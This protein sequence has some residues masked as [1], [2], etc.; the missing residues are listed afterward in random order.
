M[1]GVV[2]GVSDFASGEEWCGQDVHQFGFERRSF[3]VACF[4]VYGVQD[5]DAQDVDP[6]ATGRSIFDR[7]FTIG[8]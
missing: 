6:H 2:V 3:K 7:R 1:L 5:M 8:Y 4:H